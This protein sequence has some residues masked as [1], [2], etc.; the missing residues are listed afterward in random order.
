MLE[1]LIEIPSRVVER[2]G[3]RFGESRSFGNAVRS[4]HFTAFG[5]DFTPNLRASTGVY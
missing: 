5:G 2:G 4:S 3:L 1:A